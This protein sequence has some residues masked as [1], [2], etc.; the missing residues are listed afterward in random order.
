MKIRLST[1]LV[2]LTR[3]YAVKI[4]L[5]KRGWLQGVNEVKLWNKYNSPNLVPVVWNMGGIVCQKKAYKPYNFRSE[6]VE[7][8][9][10]DIP[11]LNVTRCDLYN[12]NN[13]GVYNGRLVLVDY[14]I[15]EE[16]S[17]M[18]K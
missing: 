13:W 10:K 5:D 15:T 7:I 1:R 6:Y 8:V 12:P 14:G 4:P 11:E 18:Y 3:K 9:K 2:L 17:K 16:V